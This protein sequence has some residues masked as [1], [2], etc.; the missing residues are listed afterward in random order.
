MNLLE[1]FSSI[2][3]FVFDMDG[4]ITDGSLMILSGNE[5]V[6]TM[7]I[8][9]GYAL[10]LAVKKGY[11]VAVISG[12]VS[13]P[14]AERLEYL[15][16]RNVFMKVKDKEEVLA[17]FLLSNHLKWEETLF[18]GD[19]IPDLE[20][21]KLVGLSAC[22]SDAVPEIKAVSTFISTINGG[23][24]CVREVIEKVL[25][26]NNDWAVDAAGVSSL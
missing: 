10:Q 22:P 16:V 5:Y 4:V 25:K 8:K 14:C 18:M 26:L 3:T 12:S 17:Q 7:N 9:D 1:R 23:K 2:K 15:G 20:V 6:R 24:G 13:K 11:N 21:M 19:D